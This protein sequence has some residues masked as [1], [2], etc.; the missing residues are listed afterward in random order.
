MKTEEITCPHCNALPGSLQRFGYFS[1]KNRKTK[2]QRYR[3]KDC[4]KTFSDATLSLEYRQRKPQ[5]NREIFLDLI[6]GT[7]LKQIPRKHPVN[8]KTVVKRLSYFDKV[9]TRHNEL[10]LKKVMPVGGFSKIQ[11]DDMESSQHTKLK[12]L[13]IPMTVV[14]KS[15]YIISFDVVS[16][17]AKGRLAEISV[18][19]YG[20]RADHR[21]IGWKNVLTK[22]SQ[23]TSK[24]VVVTSDSHVSYPKML[25]ENLPHKAHIRTLSR[26]AVVAGMGEMKQGGK[27]PLFSFNHTAAMN[28]AH[29]NRLFRRT[30][31]T[32]KRPDK[33][34]TH[35]KMYQLW[36]NESI[37]AKNEGRR[38]ELPFD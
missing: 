29:V 38:P 7:S 31:C 1:K 27:D 35:L 9:A 32:T 4:R 12:P 2:I 13:S 30:W 26:A 28:R 6:S 18:K 3:C 36:H 14:E 25:R 5:L 17:P 16:M 21:K 20:K 10:L 24:D 37:L 11:F 15:R 8:Y 22:T 33:L 23:F 34:V 19:K